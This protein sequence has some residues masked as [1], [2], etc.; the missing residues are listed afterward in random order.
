MTRL[1][2]NRN[3]D[4]LKELDDYKFFVRIGNYDLF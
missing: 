3:L 2:D 1:V 4:E